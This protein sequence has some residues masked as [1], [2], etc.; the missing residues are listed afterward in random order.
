M[1]YKCPV[2]RLLDNVS[3][4]MA[5]PAPSARRDNLTISSPQHKLF[6]TLVLPLYVY[7]IQENMIICNL[8]D[9]IICRII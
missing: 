5:C 3:E 7:I 9:L 1:I 8:P 6:V 2:V 4:R